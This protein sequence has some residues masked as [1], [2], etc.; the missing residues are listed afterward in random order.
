MWK[1]KEIS[2]YL[3]KEQKL[4]A[5]SGEF[6]CFFLCQEEEIFTIPF[7]ETFL[8]GEFSRSGAGGD[9]INAVRF[10]A[11]LFLPRNH[12]KIFHKLLLKYISS[13]P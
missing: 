10:K 11:A 9:Q 7:N 5:G 4:V 1:D 8:T 6:F 13:V 2:N 12:P 3:G